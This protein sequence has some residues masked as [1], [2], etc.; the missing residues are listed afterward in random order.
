MEPGNNNA[1]PKQSS[2]LESG[3]GNILPQRK[4]PSGGK[5]LHI[6]IGVLITFGF[7]LLPAPEPLT[8][9][10]MIMIGYFIGVVYLWS[11][12]DLGW[13]SIFGVVIVSFYMNLILEPSSTAPFGMWRTLQESLGN[14]VVG[15]VIG[16]LLLTYALTEVGFTKR[17]AQIFITSRFARKGAWPFTIMFL[18]AVLV[19]G[20]FIDA[21]PTIVFFVALAHE[22]FDR[23]GYK[24]G[25]KY[26]LMLIL[27]AGFITNF[28]FGMTPI[29]HPVPVI[30]MSIFTALTGG[31]T[32]SFFDYMAV[33]VPVGLLQFVMLLVFF[34]Y[35]MRPDTS[36]F[37]SID[38]DK[39]AG[40]MMPPMRAREKAAVIVY[41]LVVLTW[42]L[43]GIIA[44]FAPGS[45]IT[46]IFDEMTLITPTLAGVIV[47]LIIRAEDKPLLD[48]EKAFL[49][50]AVPFKIIAMIAC[51]MLFGT[52]LTESATGL[53]GFIMVKMSPMLESNMSPFMVVSLLIIVT[54]VGANL[55]NHAPVTILFTAAFTPV[56]A[57]IGIAPKI[58]GTL[59]IFSAQMGF[60][61]PPVLVSIA[62]VSGDKYS[63]I[64]KTIK[65]G[66]ACMIIC[67]IATVFVGYPL[68]HAIFRT[69]V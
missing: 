55:L 37:S 3:N 63:S 58:V 15:Y 5:T 20:C 4:A 40:E 62:V 47:M 19:T 54:M 22:I 57:Q 32:I 64:G 12:V 42:L 59:V 43:P 33:A 25:E 45:G 7:G 51:A 27:G 53:N 29:S 69:G 31:M 35:F 38:I 46:R 61:L 26:P 24:V 21:A 18:L 9:I 68:A 48:L 65:Y 39:L 49:S 50:G 17:V 41:G 14:W 30:G 36:R 28:A 2:P 11:T 56:A 13:P 10:G 60:M 8:H 1:A 67:M 23:L 44:M 66:F 6:I 16:A 52:V 34:R